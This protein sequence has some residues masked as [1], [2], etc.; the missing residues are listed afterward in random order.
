MSDKFLK[1]ES[2][3]CGVCGSNNWSTYASGKD[4]EY[5]TSTDEFQMVECQVCGNIYLNPRPAQEEL[6]VIY[7]PNYYSYNY[8][9]VINHVAIRAKDWLD[10]IKVKQWMSYLTTSTP[11]FLDVGCG[12]GRHLKMLYRLGVPKKYLYGVELSKA[13]IEDL[14]SEGFQ[15]Y[16]GR[17]E[18]VAKKLPGESF[19]L[20]VLLQVLEH[21]SEPQ[22]M[23]SILANLLRP[24]G[25]LIIETPNTD[26]ID[27][28][29]FKRSYWGGYHFPRHWNLM[30]QATLTRLAQTHGLEVKAF[31]FLPSHSFWIFSFHHL[32]ED[33]W[34]IRWLANFFNPFQNLIL[35]TLFTGFDIVRAKIGYQTSNIQMVAVK[36]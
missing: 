24:G 32:I 18:D 8:D 22:T 14:N 19:D 20:I 17:I 5:H 9:K 6:S 13:P 26:S 3:F 11:R 7:P 12:N 28:K 27:V 29:L 23:I 36:L 30:N 16:F 33:K 15:G 1:L 10:S 25:V 34:R 35:L 4:Y 31:K 21:V 2:V